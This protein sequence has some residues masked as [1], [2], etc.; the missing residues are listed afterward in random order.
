MT[1][2]SGFDKSCEQLHA[3]LVTGNDPIVT[4]EIA[5]ALLPQLVS[6]LRRRFATLS[7]EQ[8]ID[9]AAEDA[10]LNYFTDPGQ[11]DPTKGSLL[12]WLW[13]CARNNLL[14][15]LKKQTSYLH[16]EKSVELEVAE[17]VYQAEAEAETALIN[18]SMDEQTL[19]QLR[20]IVTDPADWQFL[21]LMMEG[22]RE[23]TVFAEA[24]GVSDFPIEEQR[25]LVKQYKDRLK[26]TIQRH[27]RRGR[28]KQ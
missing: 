2:A 23:T 6:G 22:I 8:L 11:F 13:Q 20:I 9:S 15:A 27:F 5:E 19:Q 28:Q 3:R 10:L 24:A 21:I 17:T 14:N 26:K 16:K 1:S 18:R 7:D 12:A 25:K 4:S